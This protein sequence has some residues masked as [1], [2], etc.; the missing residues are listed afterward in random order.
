MLNQRTWIIVLLIFISALL[1][2]LVIL[3][4]NSEILY[5]GDAIEYLRLGSNLSEG[6]GFIDHKTGLPYAYWP[7]GWPFVISLVYKIFGQHEIF[8]RV[9]Q[10]IVSAFLCLG[11]FLL[12]KEVFNVRIGILAALFCTLYPAFL[13]PQI[14]FVNLLND[15]T[16]HL[17]LVVG[18]ILFFRGE[19][20]TYYYF[21]SGLIL[22]FNALV[23]PNGL[24]VP[25]I[26]F[27]ILLFQFRFQK[28][29][30]RNASLIT[31]G[32]LISVLPWTARNYMVMNR[33]V[34]VSTNSGVNMYVGNATTFVN[35]LRQGDP[36][37]EMVRAQGDGYE[38]GQKLNKRG[39]EFL[40]ENVEKRPQKFLR[41][42]KYHFDPFLAYKV[43][44]GKTHETITKYNWMYTFLVPFIIF[45]FVAKPMDKY[46][47]LSA[48]FLSIN[49]LTA[50]IYIG[51]V[52]YRLAIE[53]LLIIVG[54]MG[55]EKFIDHSSLKYKGVL[56]WLILNAVIGGFFST[57]FPKILMN[58]IPGSDPL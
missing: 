14:G 7:P 9:Y 37:Y 1:V 51:A 52:R 48:L 36:Y 30:I 34:L 40:V 8:L 42:L 6:K 17:L 28:A 49:T 23:K 21:F 25:V 55:M 46:V 53:P 32:F 58:I 27:T 16:Y 20:K 12:A 33:L 24:I 29:F 45:G 44:I 56:I 26:L 35:K 10:T 11:V 41:K 50:L 43:N 47:I 57:E 5:R 19:K 18:L 4:Y 22:G 15:P 54:F 39:I 13:H 31:L 38:D 3:R 2:R